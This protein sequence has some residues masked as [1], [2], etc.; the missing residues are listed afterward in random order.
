MSP[1]LRRILLVLSLIALPALAD[2]AEVKKAI[3]EKLPKLNTEGMTVTK[4]GVLGLYEVFADGQLFY[5]DE[6]AH[7]LFLGD[8]VDTRSMKSMTEDRMRTLTAIKFDSL[9]L[10]LAIKQVKGNGK[11]KVAIFSDPDCPYCKRLETTLNGVTDITTY[12]FLYPILALH[13]NAGERAKGV[14]CASDRRKAW[15]D[16]M[17]RN[18]TPEAK[19]CDS[20][21]LDTIAALGQKHKINGTPTLV[22]A[23]GQVI[24]GAVPA[25]QLEKLLN[26]AEERAGK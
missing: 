6:G 3:A 24:P 17:Q 12:T 20:S 16:Y 4:T 9:P 19:G 21:A 13:P 7:Y 5:T 18:L 15:D 8:I 23:D 22:F 11:R 14:W 1:Y 2:V 25:D 26:K 10:D